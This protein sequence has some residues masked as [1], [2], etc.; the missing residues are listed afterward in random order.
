[1]TQPEFRPLLQR[2]CDGV[3]NRA[4]LDSPELSL[5]HMFGELSLR[6]NNEDI[7]VNMPEEA[8]DLEY[9]HLIDANDSDRISIPRDRKSSKHYKIFMFAYFS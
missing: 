9:I 8:Y 6:F 4:A 7:V 5:K 2:L 3:T 1:M